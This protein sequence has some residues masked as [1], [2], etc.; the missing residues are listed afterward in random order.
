MKP[1]KKILFVCGVS[2]LLMIS[3]LLTA[4]LYL[5][6]HP[7]AVKQLAEKLVS[8]STG[9]TLTI[10][11]LSYSL[12]PLHFQ[13]KGIQLSSSEEPSRSRF[14]LSRM[15]ADVGF[16]GSFGYKTLLFKRL[17]VDGFSFR[18]LRNAAMFQNGNRKGSRSIA[19][20]VLKSLI[21]FFLFRDI[22][23]QSIELRNGDMEVRLADQRFQLAGIRANLN[24]EGFVEMSTQARIEVPS[25]SFI[26]N[27][28]EVGIQTAHSISFSKPVVT[29]QIMARKA[30]FQSP[31][32]GAGIL[33]LSAKLQYHHGQKTISLQPFELH[34]EGIRM[35][36]GPEQKLMP[37][38][39]H[40][41]SE[42]LVELEGIR[43]NSCR[44]E[45]KIPS[46]G[47]ISGELD[48]LFRP[49]MQLE[50]RR[51]DGHVIPQMLTPF[52][53][54][55]IRTQ[56]AP[57]K[58]S[59]PLRFKGVIEGSRE[60]GEWAWQCDVKARFDKNDFSYKGASHAL[61]GTI[62]G[63]LGVRGRFPSLTLD[64]ELKVDIR[65]V[66]HKNVAAVDPFRVDLSLTGKHPVY[67]VRSL[68]AL[69][70]GMK[71]V[72]GNQVIQVK[73]TEIQILKGAFDADKWSLLLPSVRVDSS[74]LKH[75]MMSLELNHKRAVLALEGKKPNLLVCAQALDL[76]PIE[77]RFSA[78]DSF[79]LR[80]VL[81][82]ERK[83]SYAAKLAMHDL[84]FESWDANTMGENLAINAEMKGTLDLRADRFTTETRIQMERGELLYDRFYV[85]LSVNPFISALEG[86]YQFSGK[87]LQ[88]S[89]LK[90]GLKDILMVN[91]AG[92]VVHKAQ[93]QRVQFTLKAPATPLKPVFKH[94]ILGPFEVEKP[95]LS[96]LNVG[97]AISLDLSL[98]GQ[99]NNWVA[100]GSCAWQ[101][102]ELSSP[103][104][105]L[106]LRGIDLSLPLWYRSGTGGSTQAA[107][108]GSLSINAMTLPLL[109]KQ[110]LKMKLSA[111]PNSLTATL[112]SALI[113][114]GGS[115]KFGSITA[116][117]IFRR[118]PIIETSLILSEVR[119]API[120]SY[121]WPHRAQGTLHGELNPIVFRGGALTARGEV[122]AKVFDGKVILTDVHA[123]RFF[124][125]SPLFGLDARWSDLNLEK[126]TT[127]TAFGKIE[128]VLEGHLKHLEIAYGQPQRF[129][130]RMET[131]KKKGVDQMISVTAL[132]NIA[133]I[134]GGQSPF[135]GLAG[136]FAAF[137]KKFPYEKLGVHATLENDVFRV[138]GTIREG[139]VE[140]LVKRGGFSGV[141]IVNQNPDNRI[142]FKDMVKRIKRVTA[143][144]GR[145][146]I[147]K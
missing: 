61:G 15:T 101:E 26:F 33:D 42:G 29:F 79:S 107:L 17:A 82:E 89:N 130:L 72:S 123:S 38:K 126:L 19:S 21:G 55:N 119:V 3:A 62:M 77:W 91:A 99:G 71:F 46:L 64:A 116:T 136:G 27:A 106:S 52:L 111:A 37:V 74:L 9:A 137:F 35:K 60:K 104:N 120:L 70:P 44:F 67:R 58:L 108:I 50:M 97:G 76:I 142:S 124:S 24:S 68:K 114:P 141:N 16:E 75:L 147:I 139:G 28:P 112:P 66:S 22:A 100:T 49:P 132:E 87:T 110:S 144:G 53:A 143:K 25:Q 36:L 14:E 80:I 83:G 13:V 95:F 30:T 145:G 31:A 20:Q 90:A 113:V 102:G 125:A 103:D 118:K 54:E 98:K 140:Y 39:I 4:F 63:N 40:F 131:F 127:G 43:L 6:H 65:R 51:I 146:P 56:V 69:V 45:L 41:R 129:D 121:F 12:D 59:G 93:D 23:F 84:S 48:G 32:V 2:A 57:M 11:R 122:T 134:G 18:I 7:P 88:V 10:D 109:P 138:N 1:L 8:R 78:V 34:G 115:A 85:D 133:Q 5:Y 128:G 105:A 94:L 73:G 92:S 117:N 135:M 81:E 96:T 47:E 86:N